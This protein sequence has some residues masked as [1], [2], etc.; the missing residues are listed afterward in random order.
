MPTMAKRRTIQLGLLLG[1]LGLLAFVVVLKDIGASRLH[2]QAPSPVTRAVS[3]RADDRPAIRDGAGGALDS[4][5]HWRERYL[6][7]SAAARPALAAQGVVLAAARSKQIAALARLEPSQAGARL[8]SLAELAELPADVR[9]VCEQPLSTIGSI[10]LRWG[11]RIGTDES[12]ECQHQSVA[13][14]GGRSWRVNGPDYREARPPRKDVPIDGYVIEGELFI[15][16]GPVRKLDAAD[17]AAASAKFPQGNADGLDPVTGNPANPAAAALIGGKVFRFEDDGVIN[18]VRAR[19][20]AAD[21]EAQANQVFQP[22]SGFKW[23]AADGGSGAGGSNPPVEPTPFINDHLNVLFIRVD[24]SDKPG[25]PVTQADLETSLATTNGHLQNY[26][27]S[28][29]SLTSTVTS[30]LYRMPNPSTTYT[31]SASGSADLLAAARAL[32]AANYTL[33]NYE[34]VGVYF[35][36]LTGADFNYSGL[37]SV[38]GGDHWINGLTSNASRTSVMV[39]EFGHNYGLFHSNY[40]DPAQQIGG[41]YNDPAASSLEYGDIFDR[42][43]SAGPAEGYFSPFSTRRLNW[44]PVGK[45]VQPVANGTWRIYR[46]DAPTALS[47]P[48][49]AL[50]VPMGGNEYWWVGYRRLP[51]AASPA[52]ATSAYVVA[53]GLYVNHPNLLDMT[54]GSLSPESSDRTDAGLP[55]GSQYHDSARGVTIRT[56]TSGG[57]A[58]NE[59]IDVQVEFESRIQFVTTAVEVDEQAGTAVLT[60]NRSFGTSGVVTVNYTSA[61]G[62][63][64][65]GSDYYA[66]SGSVTWA[67]GDGADKQIFVPIRPD[68]VNDASENLTVALSGA[69]GATLI[70]AQP[71]ATVT[72][73]DAGQRFSSFAPD[74]FS[75]TVK[76]IVPLADGKVL[77]A[78]NMNSGITGH[79]ARLNADASVDPTFNKGTG[80]NGEVRAL[81]VDSN[82]KILAGG[83]FT[84]YNSTPCNRLVRLNADGTVDSV[85]VAAMGT[86]A[87]A[88]VNAIAIETGGKILVGGSFTTFAGGTMEGL[89]RLTSTGALDTGSPLA[90][91]F[92]PSWSTNIRGLIAQDDGKIMAI[93]ELYTTDHPVTGFRSGIARLNANGTRDPS[94]DPDAGLHSAGQT[95]ELRSGDSIIR[96]ADG[97]YVIGGSFPAYD[98]N[99]VSNLVRVNANGTYDGSF[100]SPPTDGDV[101]ALQFQPSGAI[102]IGGQFTIPGGRLA[103]LLPSGS[104]DSSFQQGSGAAGNVYTFAKSK[105]GALWIGGNFFSYNGV[106]LYPVVKA[107]SGVSGYDNWVAQTLTAAQIAS[108]IADP[109]DDSDN[110]GIS[111]LAE[112]ALGT[113]PTAA[114]TNNPFSSQ[115]AGTGLVTNG[116]S[117]YLQSR[118]TRNSLYPGVWLC[119]QFSNDLNAWS[120]A[121]PLPGTNAVYDILEDG[122]SGFTVRDKTPAGAA[123]PK[124]FMRFVVRKPD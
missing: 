59:W 100:V 93:G 91:P 9:A 120:P 102:V 18:R 51:H 37:A 3:K 107:A 78:G 124:R 112:M 65:A 47:N 14:A 80:F 28:V 33:A 68:S 57:S 73:R 60:L 10:D 32:A 30:Q 12:L 104:L 105:D 25:A 92:E 45:T 66:V 111:N 84:S 62:T 72:I 49:M 23:L 90:L 1:I 81:A 58:P 44:L 98:E 55:V 46:F 56:L 82:G 113:S 74:F 35:P 76:A 34:V 64:T 121:S 118:I 86:G 5:D 11:A 17:L 69:V 97:K 16:G 106:S 63:A 54:P 114:N 67:D 122:A 103:R 88:R 6:N 26:S 101:L 89:V 31:A 40:W 50:R 13:F 41:S 22:D 38:G 77:I 94:F 110:D 85:F 119:A 36:A 27:Y 123:M 4:F 7:A 109:T 108:G 19:L 71:V 70:P 96:Q 53:E 115:A 8:L 52:L 95:N 21:R 24:F 48:L 39:H 99:P 29:A 2:Q 61:N 117:K 79:I 116:L 83:D 43:G 20:A 75:S 87:N 42:M 15:G